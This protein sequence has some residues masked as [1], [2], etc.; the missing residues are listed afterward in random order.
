MKNIFF[1]IILAVSINTY[2]EDN[3]E[4]KSFSPE[5][6][7]SL[8]LQK[9]EKPQNENEE[10][11][12]E[13][14]T[15][16]EEANIVEIYN[17]KMEYPQFE[18]GLRYYNGT[19]GL[20]QDYDKAIFWF[21]N[22]SKD[23]ENSNADMMLASMYYEGKGFNLN[24]EKAISFYTRAANRGNLTAQLI[25][26]GLFFFNEQ[27]MNQ[28]YA[29]YWI[30][31]SINNNSKE[32]LTLKTLILMKEEDFKTLQKLIPL[33]EA[34]LKNESSNFTLGYLYFTGKSVKQDF[35]K[36]SEYLQKSALLGN[37]ISV[38]MLEEI[39]KFN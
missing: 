15:P 17:K 28:E 32:A 9:I 35:V 19:N 14:L 13:N 30:Y 5:N 23:E 27:F 18:M 38:I 29:N 22:S 36:A 37:P 7:S 21:S 39:K 34:D 6:V 1:L 20:P 16:V 3:L 24:K 25:L 12:K 33:Y 4:Q 2:A 8:P 31:Q 10:V 26:T 11:N